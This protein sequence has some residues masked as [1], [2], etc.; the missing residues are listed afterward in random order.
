TAIGAATTAPAAFALGIEHGELAAEVLQHDFGRI[1]LLAVLVG[2][3]AG[4][5]SALN[6]N[7][8]ALAEVFLGDLGQILV[9]DDH[10]VPLGLLLALAGGL[11]APGFR[12]RDREVHDGVAAL[13]AADFGVLAQI[14]HQNDLVDTSRHRSRLP[15]LILGR[16][17]FRRPAARYC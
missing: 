9:E 7:L 8:G 10:A 15:S 2:V 1:L 3:F 16:T 17:L 12:G 14:A 5:E 13:H 4:L 11:I 6:V